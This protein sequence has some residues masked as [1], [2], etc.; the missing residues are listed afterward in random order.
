MNIKESVIKDIATLIGRGD[1][2]SKKESAILSIL[3]LNWGKEKIKQRVIIE[4]PYWKSASTG[5]PAPETDMREVRRSIRRL[6]VE[7]GIPIM[8]S[9]AG[10]YLP[11]TQEDVDDFM[12][13]LEREVTRHTSSSFETYQILKDSLGA[14]SS[15]LDRMDVAGVQVVSYEKV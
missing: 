8:H 13:R 14:T 4:H 2:V 7:F 15:L 9:S 6:R 10:H 5:N 3:M 12:S 1:K 11:E